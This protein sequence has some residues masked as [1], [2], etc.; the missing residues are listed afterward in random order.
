[1]KVRFETRSFRVYQHPADSQAL[2][3]RI[4]TLPYRIFLL[5]DFIY[6]RLRLPYRYHPLTRHGI[7]QLQLCL[8]SRQVLLKLKKKKSQRKPDNRGH[9]VYSKSTVPASS[10]IDPVRIESL[11]GMVRTIPFFLLPSITF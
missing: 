9:I 2:A 3:A 5:G 6:V 4:T 11:D 8:F 1:L 10:F 7:Y